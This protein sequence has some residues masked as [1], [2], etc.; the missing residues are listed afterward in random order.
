MAVSALRRSC[1]TSYNGKFR[2]LRV[3]RSSDNESLRTNTHP[4]MWIGSLNSL[5]LDATSLI[6]ADL[7][8][9]RAT[10]YCFE[11]GSFPMILTSQGQPGPS[12]V[13]RASRPTSCT[14]CL[15]QGPWPRCSPTSCWEDRRS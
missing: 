7:L 10:H 13:H 4:L 3:H 11:A 8:P 12:H 14:V 9:D 15:N 2:L 1:G 5:S 6:C